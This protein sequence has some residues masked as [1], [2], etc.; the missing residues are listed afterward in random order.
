MDSYLSVMLNQDRKKSKGNYIALGICNG[1]VM[2]KFMCDF[3]KE[4]THIFKPSTEL[5]LSTNRVDISLD[6]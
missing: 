2:H 5:L 4:M 6:I 3:T 1:I